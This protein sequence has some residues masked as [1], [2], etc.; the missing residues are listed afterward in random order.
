MAEVGAVS[1]SVAPRLR[2]PRRAGHRKIKVTA[3]ILAAVP[4][5]LQLSP[6]ASSTREAFSQ[7]KGQIGH[8]KTVLLVPATP[9]MDPPP[10]TALKGELPWKARPLHR[11]DLC[12]L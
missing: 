9:P 4:L 3:R 6:T 2:A 5:Y 8:L 11:P 12:A 7:L 1:R 10:I